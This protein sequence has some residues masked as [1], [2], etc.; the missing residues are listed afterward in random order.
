M[1][2][3]AESEDVSLPGRLGEFRT[4]LIEEIEAATRH[5]Q[6]SGVPLVNGKR[7]AQVGSGFQYVF[8]IESALNLPGDVPGELFIPERKPT[9]VI[10]I[11]VEGMAVTLS[12]P[13]DLGRFVP[14]AR[15]QS[16]L[17]QLMRRLIERI[18]Q[19]AE[20]PNV[21]GDRILEGPVSGEPAK[22]DLTRYDLNR[23]Q[24]KAVSLSMGY[25]ACF[26]E[27]P[28]GTGKTRT[29]G[30]I[31]AEMFFAGR[32]ML[33]VSHTNVAVDQALLRI[34]DLVPAAALEEGLVIR[35]GDPKDLRVN[36]RKD[37]LLRTHV[38]KRSA[39]LAERRT[40]LQSDLEVA[41]A[42]VKDVCRTIDICEWIN[43]AR[44]DITF[45]A[46]DIDALQD[47]EERI[48]E[49]RQELL[50]VED[51]FDY[52]KEAKGA[53]EDAVINAARL[54]QLVERICE[55][56]GEIKVCETKLGDMGRQLSRE[57]ALLYETHSVGWL[58]RKWKG[59]P[60][61]QVQ[62]QVVEEL[63]KTCN[64]QRGLRGR[65]DDELAD[66]AEKRALLDEK[67]GSF[68]SRYL[69]EPSRILEEADAHAAKVSGLREEL[70]G[71]ERR[72]RT[73]H[74]RLKEL[75]E[76]RLIV[77]VEMGLAKKADDSLE[78]MMAS[79]RV[80]YEQAVE[81]T[82]GIELGDVQKMRESLNSQ[83]L[84]VEGEL[85]VVEEAMRKVEELVISA[86]NIVATTLTRAYLRDSIQGRQFD[87]VII[88]E[89]SMAPIPAVW[90]AA[91][92]AKSGAV[93]V[94]DPKQLPPIVIS[95]DE[96]AKKWLGRDVF[97]VA[98]VSDSNPYYVELE[99]QRRMV[100][101]ISAISNALIYGGRLSSTFA[102]L[103]G[104]AAWLK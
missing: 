42:Q 104:H 26:I 82:K 34:S 51:K 43:E 12:V 76:S 47:L 30:S 9:E 71:L 14:V 70:R 39:I 58:T 94:G 59:L 84:M 78:N 61:P 48:E 64:E 46:A 36:E 45:M 93:V 44:D 31:G 73:T 3:R 56:E 79:I 53:A 4:A 96:L 50:Q 92:L 68:R 33:L 27:G 8:D 25:N 2:T 65:F 11:S 38:D 6:S 49:K 10:V 88:D 62:L 32:S 37:L 24:Q 103:R 60:S 41:T 90:I 57:K 89:A 72:Y 17:A 100:P 40:S 16:N 7:I 18:E 67:V 86:A 20:V 28:P 98:G 77:L 83:I 66:T 99:E 63:E 35:V 15:L 91:S 13:E 95:Q 1:F 75:L 74:V 22:L 80:A 55:L 5:E 81:L 101:Q 21:V 19:K 29:I 87:T 54:S 97:E 23:E 52:W 85:K 102:I 69:R